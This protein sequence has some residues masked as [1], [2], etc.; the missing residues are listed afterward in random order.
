MYL[1]VNIYSGKPSKS[2]VRCQLQRSGFDSWPPLAIPH[3]FYCELASFKITQEF[4]LW[5]SSNTHSE[6]DGSLQLPAV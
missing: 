2:T 5:T 4:I 6:D 3:Q 1:S